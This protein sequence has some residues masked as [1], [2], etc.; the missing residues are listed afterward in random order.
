MEIQI[1]FLQA[2][3]EVRHWIFTR[4]LTNS[5]E[6]ILLFCYNSKTTNR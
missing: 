4:K 6:T 2:L 3:F 5:H 1:N